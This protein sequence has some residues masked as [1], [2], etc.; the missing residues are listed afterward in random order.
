[1]HPRAGTVP[2][3]G[4]RVPLGEAP[5][6]RRG[7]DLTIVSHGYMAAVARDAAESLEREGISCD[8]VD[9][10]SLSPLDLDAIV[11]SAE[12]TG[13]ALFVEEG[14]TVCGVAAELSFQVRERVPNLRVARLGALRTPV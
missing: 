3:G 5:I 2:A 4:N 14:Q 7:T 11:A 1:L 13:A 9:L 8:L 6:R 10:R 12:R